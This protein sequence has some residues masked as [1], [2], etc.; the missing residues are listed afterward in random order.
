MDGRTFLKRHKGQAKI[1][2]VKMFSLVEIPV[3]YT[4]NKTHKQE[5]LKNKLWKTH[6]HFLFHCYPHIST[7]FSTL[8]PEPLICLLS[9]DGLTSVMRCLLQS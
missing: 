6:C 4:E 3:A 1:L 9:I 8:P 7:S 5:I 2:R